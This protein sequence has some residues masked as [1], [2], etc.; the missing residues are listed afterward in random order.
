LLAPLPP[1]AQARLMAVWEEYDADTTPEARF[2][3]GLDKLETMVQHNQGKNA[4]S[5]D[6]AFN[7]GYG[8]GY[9]ER[10]PLLAAMRRQVD[11]DT[12]ERA[13]QG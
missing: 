12:R 2:V 5:F 11:E 4:P 8:T 9:T 13:R 6:Y 1:A 3:K 10:H 7:L